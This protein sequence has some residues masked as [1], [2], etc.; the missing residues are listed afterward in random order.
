MLAICSGHI[1][2]SAICCS[3][4]TSLAGCSDRMRLGPNPLLLPIKSLMKEV[5]SNLSYSFYECHNC[6]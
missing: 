3:Q 4:E 6:A 2:Y 1:Q 5:E